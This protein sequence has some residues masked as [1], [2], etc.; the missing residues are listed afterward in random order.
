MKTIKFVV[1]SI[2]AM[3]VLTGCSYGRYVNNNQNLNLNQTQVVLSG[4]N[5]KVV[6][7][8]K[9]VVAY[10]Q[11]DNIFRAKFDYTQLQK[12]AYAALLETANLTGSQALVNVTIEEVQRVQDKGV[13]RKC[14]HAIQATGVVIEFTSK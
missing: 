3:A 6:K 13:S 9:T 14:E 4:N 11:S 2:V 1:L 10:K 8:V 7:T 12:N 5:F